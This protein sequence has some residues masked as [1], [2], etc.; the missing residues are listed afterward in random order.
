[1]EHT[2]HGLDETLA[3]AREFVASLRGVTRGDLS[4]RVVGLYGDLGA[5]K[6]SFMQGVA[7]ALGV[8]EHVTS[9]TFV[10]EKVYQLEN[11]PDFDRLVHIDAYR[12]Q[13][14]AELHHIGWNELVADS[15]NLVCVEW[16][17]R[18]DDAFPAD[19]KKIEFRHKGGDEREI[20]W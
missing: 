4:A 14:G 19:A 18:V 13:G 7:R 3:L 6:T 2:T 12:L 15:R 1:M 11:D 5:G 10:I 17:E 9:P 8:E 16:A 20:V